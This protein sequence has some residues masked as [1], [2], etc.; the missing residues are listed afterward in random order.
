M[1]S[2]FC[3]DQA[4]S[5]SNLF[6]HKF[7]GYDDTIDKAIQNIVAG[8]RS[9]NDVYAIALAAYALE[10][11][12]HEMKQEILDQILAKSMKKDGR[13]WLTKGGRSPKTLNVEMTAYVLLTLLH[14]EQ[15]E[16]GL[17]FFKFLLH[18]RNDRGGFQATQDTVVGL[19]ALAKYAE[20]ISVK[21]NNIDILVSSIE[22]NETRIN[23]NSE[24]ALVLQTF[25]VN[26][27]FQFLTK[28]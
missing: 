28:N 3:E 7:P 24:N 23:V 20:R 10:L 12:D 26:L 11:A 15:Y 9:N 4:H 19:Q 6:Q 14:S 13:S 16:N 21:D 1:P 17:P 27:H 25:E 5:N 18:Q 8:L 2:K 22:T